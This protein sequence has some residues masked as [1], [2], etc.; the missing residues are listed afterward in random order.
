MRIV[1][2]A[3]MPGAIVQAMLTNTLGVDSGID[4]VVVV[5]EERTREALLAAVRDADML[6]GDYT[7]ELVIDAEVIDTMGQCRLIQQPSAG[8]QQIDVDH[9]ASRGIPVAN[10]GGAN[11]VA[12][13][14]FTV[15]AGLALLR[16]LR[17][18][19]AAVREGQWPQLEMSGGEVAEKTWG[20]VGFGRI[21][22]EVARRLGAFGCTI[23]YHDLFEAPAAIENELRV[24]RSEIDAL[25]SR[26]DVV[27][28]HCPLTDETR[29]MIG[30][31]QLKRIGVSGYLINV[32][33]GEVVVESDLVEALKAGHIAGAAIDVFETEPT[34]AENPLFKLENVIVSPHVAGV[35]NESRR[36][37]MG[38][39]VANLA[40]VARGEA[41]M[42]VVNGV[43]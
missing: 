28:L 21:G 8:Y 19:D 40:R 17:K 34:T 37:I 24:E 25:L 1:S 32:A 18:V 39:T 12:V 4:F 15:M 6:V 31:E 33:R 26:S 30:A 38:A 2:T 35:T 29:H 11:D 5:P 22:R 10:S 36:R 20:I 14:E 13:A 3:P 27:S 7:F 41:P 23:L 9:A 16:N 43:T 42:D